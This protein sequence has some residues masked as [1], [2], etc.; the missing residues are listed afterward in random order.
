MAAVRTP[1][2]EL[3]DIMKRWGG[4]SHRDLAL[5]VL[6]NRTLANGVSPASRANDR[7]WLSRYVVHAPV[8]TLQTAYFADYGESAVKVASVLSSRAKRAFTNQQI[9]DEVCGSA[10]V[11]MERALSECGQDTS[12]FRNVLGRLGT[13]DGLTE[14]QRAEVAL[15]L[16]VAAGCSADATQAASYTIDY[17]RSLH[18]A[19]VVTPSAP[20]GSAG[21][22]M[23]EAAER[24]A[25]VATMGLLRIV[26]GYVV[27]A[28][29]WLAAEPGAETVVGA[30]AE[31][32]GSLRDVG[33]DVSGR[34]ARIWRG[35]DGV[36]YVEGLESR[37]G[38]VL[39]D[40]ATRERMVVEPPADEREG[41]QSAPVPFRPGDE[42]VFAANTR[43]V[44]VAGV[45]K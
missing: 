26:D 36:W 29:F 31:Q 13:V 8:E 15:T 23:A 40:G 37:N 45:A 34:H 41:W 32:E 42:L 9:I 11:S 33:V 2:G 17:I 16:L 25:D 1:A 27:G 4:V 38:T 14:S 6:S 22:G 44:A 39:V 3:F 10:G 21:Q 19:E 24:L 35:D 7:V 28:P 5:R 43:F 18:G 30:L 12:L 20:T